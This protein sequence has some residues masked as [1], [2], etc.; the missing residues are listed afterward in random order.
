MNWFKKKNSNEVTEQNS[1]GEKRLFEFSKKILKNTDTL[2]EGVMLLNY[3]A[4]STNNAVKAVNGSINEISD[5]NSVLS[6]NI[7]EIKDISMEMG[8]NIEA[9]IQRKM[10]F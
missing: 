3:I 1:S 8:D 5:G 7:S 10:V 9:N 4:G 6:K 2:N